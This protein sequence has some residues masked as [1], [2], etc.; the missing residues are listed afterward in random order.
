METPGI[1]AIRLAKARAS[2]AV[3]RRPDASVA[4]PTCVPYVWRPLLAPLIPLI[5]HR[6]CACVLQVMTCSSV[7]V[8]GLVSSCTLGPL[9]P[10]QLLTCMDLAKGCVTMHHLPHSTRLEGLDHLTGGV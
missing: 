4:S 1:W 10:A 7:D 2:V 9:Q 6:L 3:I 5:G 8:D